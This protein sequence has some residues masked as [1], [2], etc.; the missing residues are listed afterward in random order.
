MAR[1]LCDRNAE[2]DRGVEDA[3]AVDVYWNVLFAGQCAQR[4]QIV[5]RNDRTA[6]AVVG[7]LD[8]YQRRRKAIGLFLCGGTY[9]AYLCAVIA[10]QFPG[11]I[12]QDPNSFDKRDKLRQGPNLQLLHHHLAMSFDSSPC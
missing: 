4:G 6:G 3:R 9:H 2:R 11:T 12:V 10:G 5:E 1:D 8:A 7:G